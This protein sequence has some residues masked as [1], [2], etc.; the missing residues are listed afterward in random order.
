[1]VTLEEIAG[2]D[3]NLNIPRYV[4]P[5]VEYDVV[6]V[7]AAMERLRAS[8][9]TAFSAEETATQILIRE[10]L[11]AAPNARANILPPTKALPVRSQSRPRRTPTP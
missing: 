3:Y 10:R 8:A 4:E 11:I 1:M 7:D 6:T 9:A 5:T 2:N